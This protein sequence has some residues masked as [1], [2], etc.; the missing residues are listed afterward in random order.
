MLYVTHRPQ[1]QMVM[2]TPNFKRAQDEALAVLATFGFTDPPIDPVRIARDMGV[3]V[4]F[5]EFSPEDSNVSGF[6][7]A[8][9]NKI[10][11]NREE[12]PPR[13]TFTVAH[14]L[15][16]KV[17]HSEW[18][19]SN[20]YRVLL[21]DDAGQTKEPIEREADAFAAHLLV[22]RFMLQKYRKFASVSELADLFLVSSPVIKNRLKFEFGA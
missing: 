1:R 14:E 12:Y 22:P 5:A 6:F 13:Q 9:E 8:G 3:G 2:T 17:L 19:A 18:A 21:R 15:G 10:Y 4:V 20:N 16:H 11:V 7:D